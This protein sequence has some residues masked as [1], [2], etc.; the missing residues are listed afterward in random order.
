[1]NNYDIMKGSF[2]M[3]M[4]VLPSILTVEELGK[5]LRIG[6][7]SAYNLVV[8]PNFPAIRIGRQIRVERE[9]LLQWMGNKKGVVNQ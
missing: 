6:R 2:V 7:S 1:M 5:Y 3:K 8:Q 9:A 4:N